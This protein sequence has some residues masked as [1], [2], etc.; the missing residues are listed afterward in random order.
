MYLKRLELLGFKSFATRT[1]LEFSPGIT[2]VVGPNGAGKSNIADAIRWVLGEQS[3][4]QLRGRKSEDI[5]FAGGHGK[6]ALGMA[7]VSL[8]IDNSTGWMP[9]EYSEITVTRR[10]YRSGENEYL[11]NKQKVRLRDVLL[12]L[13]QARIGH[14]S[15]TVIGQGLIDA[16]LSLRPE[17]RRSLFEDAAG[18]RPYQVQRA[19]AEQRLR[20]TEGNLQRLHDIV[21]EIEP[22][23]GPLEEQA[24]RAREYAQL[25]EEL[26]QAL[27]A[28]YHLQWRR[29][30]AV[31]TRA[32][33]AESEQAARLRQ[34]EQAVAA[35]ESQRGEL[36]HQR[37]EAQQHISAARRA[38]G[39]ANGQLQR[40]ER[41]LAVA[42]ERVTGLQ[43]QREEQQRQ[44]R[45][46]RERLI[47]TQQRLTD[48]EEAR[49]Q[50]REAL[51]EAAQALASL[52]A[53]VARVQKDYE[54]DERR[55]RAAQND[56][57]QTQARLGATQTE[58]GRQQKHLGER[59]RA[60]ATRR[61]AL[62]QAQQALRSLETRLAEQRSQLQVARDEEQQLT[63]R[64]QALQ[65]SLQEA[66]QELE[67]LKGLLAE[68]ERARRS[69]A[70]RLAML[71]TWQR[72]LSGYSEGVRALLRAPREQ[73]PGLL[74]PLPRLVLAPAGLER[75]IEAALG[76]A[77]Q[78]VVVT[79]RAD[80]ERCL[81]YLERSRAGRALLLWLHE[82]PAPSNSV[83]AS[84]AHP[85]QAEQERAALEQLLSQSPPLRPAVLGLAWQ[86]VECEDQYQPLC[87]RLL[88]GV[89]LVEDLAAAPPIQAQAQVFADRAGR[90]LRALVTRKGEVLS[91]Q[92]GWLSGGNAQEE[93][94]GGL[95]HYE[96]ELRELPA[97]LEEQKAHID[98]LNNLMSE[99]QRA[100]EGRRAEQAALEREIQKNAARLQELG[101]ALAN[102]EREQERLQTELKLATSV[103]QQLAAEIAGL[104]QEVQ[105]TRE[106]VQAHE[107]AQQELQ[108]LV[109][110]LQAQVEERAA[111]Y[112]R[113]QEELGRL[114]TQMAVKR[115]EAKTLEHQVGEVQEQ[116]L[117]LRNQLEQQQLRLRQ[118]EEQQQR[119]H[120]NITR[121]RSELE[122]AREQARQAG[123]LVQQREQ[124]LRELEQRL[125]VS[126]QELAT[127]RQEH[128]QCEILYRRCLLES[129]RA[130]DALEALQ[131]QLQED[132]G[133]SH[134][135][136]LI[137]LAP[138]AGPVEAES[139]AQEGDEEATLRRLRRQI[140]QARSRLKAL[141]GCDPDAPRQY[142]E[143]RQRFEFLSSQIADME[144]AAQQLHTI[145]SQLDATMTRQFETTFE[146]VNARF[147]EHF[148]TLF[149]GGQARLELVVSKGGERS[150][151]GSTERSSA[152]SSPG[153]LRE[154]GHSNAARNG[155]GAVAEEE[156]AT[157]EEAA[158]TARSGLPFGVEVIVQ[159]PGKKVQD[160]SLL[161]G[162]ERA[163]VSAALLFSLLEINPPPF[164]LLDE[165][166]A[167]LDE[168]NV[169]RFCD[170]LKRLAERTQFIVITHN[171]VTMTA[172][173][174]IYGVSMGSDSVSRLASLRLSEAEAVVA[175][176]RSG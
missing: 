111:A 73:V 4:R 138:Q 26:R 52:E 112:R 39:E 114:R 55:L 148:R 94:N 12:L 133:L 23:L 10:S 167:A 42:E 31:A 95:L 65:R 143:E 8:T 123:L 62:A 162:G 166:D 80:A 32:E 64:K 113:Q 169:S 92:S 24:R 147:R 78:G 7:E 174:A 173:Q 155:H 164:C 34:L 99:I 119:L 59:N 43:R 87:Y 45:Q 53:T 79:T 14:D 28:W 36:L 11:I 109:E 154:R 21:N 156:A 60:L 81:A 130:R 22:R 49:E 141:G 142:E 63:Q 170:I 139:T 2:A 134:P 146:A 96:R 137:P 69:L 58:L 127:L 27:V 18:I 149:N 117:D 176:Q 153:G 88:S 129:Q 124:A 131:G 37:Q 106:R 98:H 90:P 48:L 175:R 61:E 105:A 1:C 75:A 76:E 51:D 140:E 145:I 93:Q 56:L 168:S 82:E 46:L 35:A 108:G 157:L 125:T 16:A 57:I 144:Q 172:A 83:P 91:L 107:R 86:L 9:S 71:R 161:S 25:Q 160:L 38:A 50:A 47:A 19:E 29:L 116:Q 132:L 20:Q 5:I 84:P 121:Q 68:A 101:R 70:D 120:E 54:L 122:Q 128:G 17:E 3:M 89:L 110:E 165:V 6:A 171:R 102:S 15:Y 151:E 159:P 100:Q 67:R 126:E 158:S 41:E 13:A 72:N 135:Q 33:A 115:Q 74:S 44:E 150:P 136:E 85:S 66:Q 40:L 163:L 103:E 118:A 30:Q 152:G 77:L 97:Q 104:E